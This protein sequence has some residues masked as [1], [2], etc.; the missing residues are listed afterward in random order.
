M[1][2]HPHFSA[3]QCQGLTSLH[4]GDPCW[5]LRLFSSSRRAQREKCSGNCADP[6]CEPP[7]AIGAIWKSICCLA[8]SA[9]LCCS[10]VTRRVPLA[11]ISIQV[12]ARRVKPETGAV[13]SGKTIK[14]NKLKKGKKKKKAKISINDNF[15]SL[16]GDNSTDCSPSAGLER[17]QLLVGL[18]GREAECAPQRWGDAQIGLQMGLSLGLY[19][20]WRWE[21]HC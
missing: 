20:G 18:P 4:L 14:R 17:S 12:A 6:S 1:E 11:L 16:N 10:P 13:F 2:E 8:G 19:Q 9:W 5:Q 7:S 3:Q 15:L 21:Q